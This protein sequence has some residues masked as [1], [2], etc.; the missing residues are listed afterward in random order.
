MSLKVSRIRLSRLMVEVQ[1]F[2]FTVNYTPGASIVVPDAP[3]RDSV[4]K[5]LRQRCFREIL[6]FEGD[7]ETSKVI[8]N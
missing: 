8:E 2:D 3:N 4:P 6:P 7:E 5:P 1:D